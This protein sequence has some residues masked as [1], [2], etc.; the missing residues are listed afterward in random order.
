MSCTAAEIAE[1]KRIA[2]AKLQAR[3]AQL[4]ANVKPKEPAA[5]SG[6]SVKLG[7]KQTVNFYRSPPQNGEKPTVSLP[8]SNSNKS[9]TFLNALKAIKGVSS[10]E[11]A[12]SS[13]HPYYRPNG[14]HKPILGLT[15]EEEKPVASVFVKSVTCRPYMISAQRFAVHISGYHEQLIEVFKKIPSR[16]YDSNTRIWNFHVNDYALLQ[17]HVGDLKP[18]VLIGTI[19]K[20]VMEMCQAPS[21][22]PEHSCLASIEPKL[23]Q[24]LMPFQQDGVCFAIAQQGRIMICD[25]M[26]LG[27]TYQALAVADY[28]KDDWPLLICTTASTR[29]SWNR[30]VTELLPSVPVHCVQVLDNNQQYLLDARV[31]IISYTM[32]ERITDKLLERKFGFLIFDESHTIK[33]LKAKCTV[34]AKKLADKAR[35]VVLLSGTP[36]LSRPL[37]LFSQLQLIDKRFMTYMDFTTRYCDGKQSKFGWDANGQSNLDELKAVLLHKYMLR[38]TKAEVLPNLAKKIRETV[39]LDPSLVWTNEETKT[40]LN[41]LSEELQN[42]KGKRHDEILMRFYARTAEVKTRAVCAYL[43]TLTKE[44]FKFII[45]AHHRAMMDAITDCLNQ[46]KVHYIRIDG[47]TRSDLRACYVDTFQNKSNCKV[48]V[49]SL[50]ACNSGITLTAAEMI[51]FAEL[52]WTPSTMAQA[53][54]RAHRIGQTKPVICRYL[55]ASRTAD[56]TIWNMLNRKQDTLKNL[57][58]FCEDLKDTTHSTAPTTSNK[59]E[60]YFSPVKTNTKEDSG[61]LHQYLSTAHNETN[62]NNNKTDSLKDSTCNAEKELEEDIADFFNDDDDEAFKD[63]IF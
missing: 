37:E 16:A 33:N 21:T 23:A 53:E 14:D 34:S 15:P 39:I 43:K 5:T 24:K 22:L 42:S 58:V 61:T 7:S 40:S 44:K 9:T 59:I 49:L 62:N 19:P 17:K 63:L 46:M 2:L 27:K 38:R 1:K 4:A 13:S 20:K 60:Q 6:A 57:G 26:G 25:E 50:K 47:N 35:R 10:R 54:S 28:F 45:F 56:D 18:D 8:N 31:L 30:H 51:V 36:A 3:Q 29:D 48:A 32:M 11:I 12:R 52:D 55:M 41:A